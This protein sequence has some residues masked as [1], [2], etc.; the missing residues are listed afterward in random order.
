MIHCNNDFT[1][2][3]FPFYELGWLSHL[4]LTDVLYPFFPEGNA[5]GKLFCI[6]R[7]AR[8]LD[9]LPRNPPVPTSSNVFIIRS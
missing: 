3:F 8:N 1:F 2:S 5:E 9:T 4:L 6:K 7:D